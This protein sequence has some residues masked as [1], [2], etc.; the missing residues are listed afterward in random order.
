MFKKF[1]HVILASVLA[2][3]TMLSAVPAFA[4]CGTCPSGGTSTNADIV[5]STGS[6]L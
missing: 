3:A 5:S 1:R 6:M 4:Q 2:F